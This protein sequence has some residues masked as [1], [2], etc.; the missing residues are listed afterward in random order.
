MVEKDL[1]YKGSKKFRI[2]H[3]K[4]C[5]YICQGIRDRGK[6]TFW[7]SE[8]AGRSID[9]IL[10]H[11]AENPNKF[12]LLRR[13][14]EQIKEVVQKGILNGVKNVPE[15]RDKL[16]GFV[17]EKVWRDN[18]ILYNDNEE[19]IEVGYVEDLNNVKGKAVEDCDCMI[20]DEYVEAQRSKYKG[21]YGGS[22]E[23]NLLAKLDE[24]Y[25]RRRQNWLI[26]L[27]NFDSP[28]NPYHE[29]WGIPFGAMKYS[30][31]KRGLLY[32]VDISQDT[33]EAKHATNTGKRWQ[34][35]TYDQYS[36][37]VSALSQI[38]ESL[39]IDKPMHAVH[40][41]NFNICGTKMT[42][43]KDPNDFVFYCHDEYKF[44]P[45]KPIYSVMTQDMKVNSLFLA[46][47]ND[48][49]RMMRMR[50]GQGRIRFNNQKTA[51][52]FMT[53]ISLTE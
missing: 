8:A 9:N 35:T 11:N 10:D 33:I 29:V 27:G 52:L 7:L 31:K 50:F 32:E 46:Y 4:I 44:D 42:V 49:V 5:T 43:W 25:F 2:G 40:E 48:V 53:L 14:E 22:Q 47:N 51:A 16:R 34:G 18:I 17:H 45:T 30:D 1:F 21:G 36:N 23:P 26:M 38:D 20:F 24:T 28:T 19:H 12:T 39:L 3:P 41:Y 6:T 37:G 15:Y 13:S